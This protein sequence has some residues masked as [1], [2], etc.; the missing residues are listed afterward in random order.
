MTAWT[1]TSVPYD[2]H[3]GRELD[4]MLT[5]AKPFA[6]FSDVY[7]PEPDEEVIPQGAFAPYVANGT[8][9]MCAF[10][11]LLPEPL[12]QSTPQIR[13]S[14]HVFY[15]RP[16]ET[17]RFDAFIAL[18]TA[19]DTLGWSEEFERR[20]GTLLGYSAKEN[21]AHIER[22]LR[23][24]RAKNFPWLRRLLEQ[25]NSPVGTSNQRLERP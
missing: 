19:A 18:I 25:R 10:V 12:A 23:S 6:H 16:D 8:F 11:E 20:E 17:W 3:T 22:M 5:R 4:F 21:D 14:V 7:P 1:P 15:A 2:I 13:G 9:E 24:P